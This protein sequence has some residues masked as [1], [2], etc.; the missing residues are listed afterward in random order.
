MKEQPHYLNLLTKEFFEEYYL[1]K[2]MSYPKI[3]DMLLK[4]GYNIHVGTLYSY[5]KKYGI[6]RSIATSRATLDYNSIYITEELIEYIDGFLIGDGAAWRSSSNNSARLSCG[7]EHE[8]FCLYLINHFKIYNPTI[9]KYKSNSM[10]NGFVWNGRTKFHP[11][12][13]PHW[14]R[15]YKTS[16]KQPPD[17]VRITPKSVTMWYLGDGSLVNGDNT[18]TIRLST[19]AFSKEKVEFL[20]S[21]LNN[22]GIKCHRN[23][24]NRIQIKAKGVPAFFEFIGRESPIKCYDYKF[25]LPEWRFK[26]KRMQEIAEEYGFDYQKLAYLVKIGKISCYRASGNGKPR[27]L[28][29]HIEQAKTVYQTVFGIGH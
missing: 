6:G 22:I 8:E 28:P 24:D 16:K 1:N 5:S 10:R 3:R 15:W 9:A 2:K 27:F 12:L 14:L 23:N 17:D 18:V 19:D 7:V 4:E 11:D 25:Y 29:E 21:I 20:A 13:Y 26:A